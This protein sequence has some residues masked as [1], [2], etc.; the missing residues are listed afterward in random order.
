MQ[1][2][3]ILYAVLLVFLCLCRGNVEWVQGSCSLSPTI[4]LVCSLFLPSRAPL[5]GVSTALT[6]ADSSWEC[7]Q[8]DGKYISHSAVGCSKPFKK[9][10]GGEKLFCQ[11]KTR[12]SS[13][14]H[15]SLS[16][17]ISNLWLLWSRSLYQPFLVDH[18]ALYTYVWK[19]K[20]QHYPCASR[21]SLQ[22]DILGWPLSL[23]LSI[24]FLVVSNLDYFISARSSCDHW[25]S[26]KQVQM[27][28]LVSDIW[29][30][31]S[32]AVP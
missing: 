29:P 1:E 22:K 26:F 23:D 19:Q 14:S 3:V 16:F 4:L 9:W 31:Q 30:L 25:R 12:A 18:L 11:V 13:T 5:L 20:P 27:C 28:F 2:A 10:R 15:V 7:E 21:A 32:P 24:S 17:L 6:L 8:L